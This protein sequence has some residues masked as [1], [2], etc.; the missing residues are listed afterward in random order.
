M[1]FKMSKAKHKGEKST[2]WRQLLRDRNVRWL[3]A[4]QIISQVGEG[5][6]K[7]ALLWFVYAL[8]ESALKMSL[9]GVLQTVPPLVFGPFAGVLLDR[10]E[11]RWA[12]IVID[13]V[14]TGLLA[15]IPILYAFDLLNLPLLYVL[16]FVIAVFSMAFG[17]ALNATLPL[18]VK[19]E[20]LTGVNALMQSAMTIGQLLGPALSGILIAAIGSQ[21][22]LYVN[23]AGFFISALTK[24]PLRL[25]HV[26]AHRT[27]QNIWTQAVKD[28]QDGI[29]FVFVKQRLLFLLM[30]VASI[31]MLGSTAFVY[32]LP[33]IGDRLLHVGSVAL[34]ALWSALGIGILATTVWLIWKPQQTVCTRVWL[35]AVAAAIAGAAVPGLLISESVWLAAGLI[36]AIGATSGLITPLVSA[37]LQERTPKDL[38]AR[39]FGLFNTGTMVSSMIGMTAFGWIADRFGPGVSLMSIG[40][41]NG[42]A[43]VVSMVVLPWCYRLA[44]QT[45]TQPQ[46]SLRRAS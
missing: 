13:L 41:V 3:F 29:R 40:V 15:T 20:Q 26:R 38:M 22:A 46:Q 8:T 31:F 21:N 36:I 27:S 45:S 24:I 16:V 23:A 42:A 14:R 34:G 37:S 12:M 7:V 11:K 18:I 33:V 35:I 43:A 2:G 6:S 1:G 5:V 9:I 44:K 39:V 19:K 32:L 10:L 17:P 4:G 25:P 30:I 28:L